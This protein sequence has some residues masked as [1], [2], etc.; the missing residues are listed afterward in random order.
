MEMFTSVNPMLR[1]AE[2]PAGERGPFERFGVVCRLGMC[3][4]LEGKSARMESSIELLLAALTDG[5][6]MNSIKGFARSSWNHSI[7]NSEDRSFLVFK[8]SGGNSW[9]SKPSPSTKR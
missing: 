5:D 4:D 9:Q 8:K 2:R 7:L 3:R 1:L 6:A